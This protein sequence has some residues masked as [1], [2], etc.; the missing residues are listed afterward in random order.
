M[1]GSR[2]IIM[3]REEETERE[4]ERERERD[5]NRDKD[6]ERCRERGGWERRGSRIEY[7]CRD[8]VDG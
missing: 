4:G 1:A 7:D 6:R 3:E 5:R 8:H 2:D